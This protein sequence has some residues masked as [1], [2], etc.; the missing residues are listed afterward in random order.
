MWLEHLTSSVFNRLFVR[1]R[2]VRP[3]EGLLIGQRVDPPYDPVV[4]PDRSRTQHLVMVGKTGFGKTHALELIASSVAARGEGFAFF[5]FH[6]DASLSLI[7]RVLALPEASQR[8]VVLD[9]SHP[10]RSPSINVLE[11]GSSDAERFRKVSELSSILRQRWGVDSFGARTEELLRNSLYTLAAA[12]RPLAELPRLL[13]DSDYR[14]ALVAHV[15]H[16]DIQTYWRERYEGLSEAM[17]GAFR[18]PLL[19]RV[20]AFLTEPAARHLLAQPD[21]TIDL[22][23]VM[24]A[25]QWLII[26]LPKGRLRE[27]AHTLGNLL[28]AQLQFAA[29][30]RDTVPVRLRR[31]FTL[32]C[33]EVQNLAENDLSTLISESRKFGISVVTANQFW[34]QLPKEL[35]GALLS[36]GSHMSFRVSSADAPI[37]G[38]ELSLAHRN[39]L[40]ID[41]T[42]LGRGEAVGRFGQEPV[43]RFRV[44][45]LPRAAPVTTDALDNLVTPATRPRTEIEEALRRP[46]NVAPVPAELLTPL[47]RRD[48]PEGHHDW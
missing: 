10:T 5:D 43:V 38:S 20:T 25:Q 44:S 1:R 6:G 27:H 32:L 30:A 31:T 21:S 14:S 35:R 28:F 4:L 26:R 8:L 46:T 3:P 42:T 24:A 11:A 33:D 40:T 36:A 34:D 29:M 22:A 45:P 7:G 37:L 9:P 12:H 39:R 41:L 2:T 18:E 15:D 13:T 17:K 16:P 48:T 47:D 23:E 19:N